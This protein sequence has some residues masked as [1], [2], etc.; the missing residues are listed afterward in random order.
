[1]HV[2]TLEELIKL[3]RKKIFQTAPIVENPDSLIVCAPHVDTTEDALLSWKKKS[4]L[5]LVGIDLLGGDAHDSNQVMDALSYLYQE[6]KIPFRL[7]VFTTPSLYTSLKELQKHPLDFF[8]DDTLFL[9][10]VEEVIHM[11]EDPLLSVRRKKGASMSIGMRLL[12]GKKIDAFVSNGNTGALIASAKLHLPMIKEI[13][14]PALLTLLPTKK[15][16]I[17][18]IDIGAN[19]QSTPHHLFQ[20]AKMAYAYQKSRGIQHPR[21]GLLNIGREKNKGGE[22][23]HAA[24]KLLESFNLEN[25][26]DKKTFIGNVEGKQIFSGNIDVLVTD[27]FTGNVF[28]KTAE[29]I[30]LFILETLLENLWE[31]PLPQPLLLCLEKELYSAEYPGA[32]LCGVDGI[33]MKCHGDANP[34]A[35]TNGV[36]GAIQLTHSHFLKKMKKYLT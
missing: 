1:M 28:L 35:I 2:K 6:I 21:I 30:S 11:N 34:K 10:K 4:S 7:L 29:G 23:L 32:I 5:P 13:T 20:F 26:K 8:K 18:V 19:I 27:G 3:R 25:G 33:I 16:P 22:D 12:K 15:A 36:K 14:R 31:V 24:Y 17:A 9:Y